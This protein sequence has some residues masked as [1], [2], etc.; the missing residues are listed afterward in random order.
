MYESAFIFTLHDSDLFFHRFVLSKSKGL[1]LSNSKR[2]TTGQ[3]V[4]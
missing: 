4:N 2:K 3:E 1:K